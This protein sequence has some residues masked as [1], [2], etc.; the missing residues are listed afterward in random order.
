MWGE[1]KTSET[2]HDNKQKEVR[3]EAIGS[4]RRDESVMGPPQVFGS[5]DPTII[6]RDQSE[7]ASEQHEPNILTYSNVPT[8]ADNLTYEHQSSYP[9]AYDIGL[10][11]TQPDNNENHP[12]MYQPQPMFINPASMN[13]SQSPTITPETINGVGGASTGGSIQASPVHSVSS[14]Y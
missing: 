4:D 11:Q 8:S 6:N 13:L 7:N 3:R 9:P 14:T 5:F 2:R 12:P 1:I 10:Q